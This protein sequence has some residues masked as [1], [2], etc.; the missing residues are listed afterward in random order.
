MNY[1]LTSC[2]LSPT[3]QTFNLYTFYANPLSTHFVS[4]LLCLFLFFTF[5][6]IVI[7]N[8]KKNG[9]RL[10]LTAKVSLFTYSN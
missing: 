1:Q 5:F 10:H 3:P 8:K 7:K 9:S 4:S 2:P 6:A